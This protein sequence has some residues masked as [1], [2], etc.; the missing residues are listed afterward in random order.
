M[1]DSIETGEP[2]KAVVRRKLWLHGWTHKA[3]QVSPGFLKSRVEKEGAW[4]PKSLI[5]QIECVTIQNPR[6]GTAAHIAEILGTMITFDAPEWLLADKGL[7]SDAVVP[8][9]P[10]TKSGITEL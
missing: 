9:Q 1:T 6:F 4:L 2:H 8:D 10:D 3:I 5:T 7:T